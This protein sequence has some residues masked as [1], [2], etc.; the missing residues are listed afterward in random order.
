GVISDVWI[1][2]VIINDISEGAGV[3]SGIT[4]TPEL[5]LTN[6]QST[7]LIKT[8]MPSNAANQE[9]NWI[10][11]NTAVATVDENGLVSA[12]SPG[13]ATITATT[14]D[15]AYQ[16]RSRITV[17]PAGTITNQNGEFDEGLSGW[18]LYD[19]SGPNNTNGGNSVSV[20]Q[21]AGLSGTNA[22]KVD[23]VNDN[24]AGWTLQLRQQLDFRLEVGRTYEI[25]FMAKA[26]TSRRIQAVIQGSPS[27]AAYASATFNRTTAAQAFTY[28]FTCTNANVAN[29]ESFGFKFYLAKGVISDVWIDKVVI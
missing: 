7:Q 18:V 23:V 22:A 16:S 3:V 15:G 25:A 28:K 29:E 8:I 26:E 20:V 19:W 1:D 21:G 2:K 14:E 24:S 9:V 5:T 6:G 12:A 10:S 27:N 4:I 17:L 13:A 11:S